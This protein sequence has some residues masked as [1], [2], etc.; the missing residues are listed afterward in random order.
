MGWFEQ[1]MEGIK[2]AGMSPWF[3]VPAS[4]LAAFGFFSATAWVGLFIAGNPEWA[5]PVTAGAFALA[6]V[7]FGFG[8]WRT[9][10]V[11]SA[12]WVAERSILEARIRALEEGRER[13][14]KLLERACDVAEGH[15]DEA[16]G[17]L[18]L[19]GEL[20]AKVEDLL[21]RQGAAPLSYGQSGLEVPRKK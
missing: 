11:R 12:S 18:R 17:A 15:R 10:T 13:D 8:C 9:L 7:V 16:Q 20:Q 1:A 21:S 3:W 6:G 14:G 5:L 2:P 4:G 19:V